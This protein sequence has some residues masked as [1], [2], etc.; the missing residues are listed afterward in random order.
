MR[1]APRGWTRTRLL[2]ALTAIVVAGSA[3]AVALVRLSHGPAAGEDLLAR[4]GFP[5]SGEVRGVEYC[6]DL[7]AA[8]LVSGL[9]P[10]DYTKSARLKTYR[11]ERPRDNRSIDE[12]CRCLQHMTPTKRVP[13]AGNTAVIALFGGQGR[14]GYILLTPMR[15]QK[16]VYADWCR[17]N[18]PQLLRWLDRI[19]RRG[20]RPYMKEWR[21]PGHGTNAEGQ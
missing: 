9:V 17:Y 14:E 13:Q 7:L 5:S 18:S 4:A 12:I 8:N 1:L 21:P 3:G 16:T 15:E 2:W 10:A 11:L 20:A 6:E 19:T